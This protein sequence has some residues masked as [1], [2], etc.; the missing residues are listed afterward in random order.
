MASYYDFFSGDVERDDV[1]FSV[2][3]YDAFGL[4]KGALLISVL[5][6]A[7]PFKGI[8]SPNSNFLCSI[9]WAQPYSLVTAQGE[10]VDSHYKCCLGSGHLIFIGG[11]GRRVPAKQTSFPG[12][13]QIKHDFL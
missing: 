5:T 10:H 8:I 13:H 12:I 7:M 2:P 6:I 4:G 1:I 3:Y 11:G 9:R